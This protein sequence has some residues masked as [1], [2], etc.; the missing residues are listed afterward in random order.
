[1]HQAPL[2]LT[3]T[4]P[5]LQPQRHDFNFTVS[6]EAPAQQVDPDK[7]GHIAPTYQTQSTREGRKAACFAGSY[8]EGILEHDWLTRDFDS[9]GAAITFTYHLVEAPEYK[10]P[11]FLGIGDQDSTF[12]GG[13]FCKHQPYE[14]YRKFPE[15]KGHEVK[16]YPDTGHLI[17]YH[18]AAQQLMADTLAFLQKYGF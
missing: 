10:G 15:V 8:D 11:V 17:L 18:H 1:M 7:W 6:V 3:T 5:L 14:V 4:L 13:Q 2:L 16:V 12:C 9:L